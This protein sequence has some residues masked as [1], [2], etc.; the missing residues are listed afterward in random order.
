MKLDIKN[1]YGQA[2]KI[3]YEFQETDTVAFLYEYLN[4]VDENV[5]TKAKLFFNGK[6]MNCNATLGDYKVKD[7]SRIDVELATPFYLY[8]MQENDEETKYPIKY[9]SNKTL[10]SYCEEYRS[11]KNLLLGGK[12][13]YCVFE[14]KILKEEEKSV[15]EL[16]IHPN[17]Y[18]HLVIPTSIDCV[19]YFLSDPVLC[20]DVISIHC[21]QDITFKRL[22]EEYLKTICKGREEERI[23]G[24]NRRYKDLK[25]EHLIIK[26]K[27]ATT[28]DS[29]QLKVRGINGNTRVVVELKM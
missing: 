20:K 3:D 18:I 28:K 15:K 22:K 13:S 21:Q 26:L 14:G 6:E 11:R 2:Y 25:P 19:V 16:G 7:K 1:Q 4:F 17:S 8:I 5:T 27:S 12:S 23:Q 10:K 24:S 9:D 29:D